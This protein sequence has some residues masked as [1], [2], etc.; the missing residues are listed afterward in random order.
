MHKILHPHIDSV[1]AFAHKVNVYDCLVIAR[2]ACIALY[3]DAVD[4][5]INTYNIYGLFNIFSAALT[6]SAT[7]SDVTDP[8]N[9]N[10]S[11]NLMVALCRHH[12]V[13]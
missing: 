4:C 12:V 10:M 11:H 3:Y 9:L 8:I 2:D 1:V 5:I 6:I 13:P 7:T